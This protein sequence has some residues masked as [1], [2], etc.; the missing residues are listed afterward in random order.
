MAEELD[1]TLEAIIR[2]AVRDHAREEDAVKDHPT[3]DAL[4]DFQE[5]LLEGEA[6]EALRQHL[7][8]CSACAAQLE[9]LEGW[10]PDEEAEPDLLLSPDELAHQRRRFEERLEEEGLLE[11]TPRRA[12]PVIALQEARRPRTVRLPLAAIYILA[13]LGLGFLLGT[14]RDSPQTPE[15]LLAENPLFQSLTAEGDGALRSSGEEIALRPEFDGLVL[16]LHYPDQTPHESYQAEVLTDSG[17][18]VRS[19]EDLP[20]QPSGTFVLAIP[21][22]DLEDGSYTVKLAAQDRGKSVPLATYRFTVARP[23]DP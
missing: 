3:V 6:A 4:V 15:V 10:D 19:W 9:R 21:R 14:L 22:G 12:A 2:Q 16:R 8:E 17:T 23:S 20:R 1:P 18:L 13:A 11:D 7:E 5:G